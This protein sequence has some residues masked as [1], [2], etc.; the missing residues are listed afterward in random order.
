MEEDSCCSFTYYATMQPGR[1]ILDQ[2]TASI[3]RVKE[4][5]FATSRLNNIR[6]ATS[7]LNIRV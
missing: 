4:I 7:G 5:S 2:Y 6:V 1:Y 3:F